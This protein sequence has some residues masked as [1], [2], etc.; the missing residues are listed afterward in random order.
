MHFTCK[1]DTFLASI[2][3][4]DFVKN[5]TLENGFFFQIL[6]GGKVFNDPLFCEDL[7]NPK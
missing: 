7:W 3:L 6:C 5:Q 4:R 2:I 1:E